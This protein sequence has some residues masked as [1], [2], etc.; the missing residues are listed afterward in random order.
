VKCLKE[1][2][3]NG[4]RKFVN[5]NLDSDPTTLIRLLFDNLEKHLEPISF[6]SIILILADYQYKSSFVADHEI[7][8]TA[9]LITIMS[10][11]IFK[12]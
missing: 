2:D 1:K 4:M 5:E 6:A 8:L 7:N 11:A 10:E 12:K 9:M 3:F